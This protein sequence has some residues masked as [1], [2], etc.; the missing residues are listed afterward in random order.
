[1]MRIQRK[2]IKSANSRNKSVKDDFLDMTA[3]IRSIQRAEGNPDCYRR[4]K[5]NCEKIDC[6]W[7]SHCLED[8]RKHE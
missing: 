3:L 4:R 5:E 8:Y 2:R 7:R 1:V 6:A